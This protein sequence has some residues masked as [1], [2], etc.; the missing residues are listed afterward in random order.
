MIAAEITTCRKVVLVMMAIAI[1][2]AAVVRVM[3]VLMVMA[4]AVWSS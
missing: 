4:N 3:N 2:T 1:A